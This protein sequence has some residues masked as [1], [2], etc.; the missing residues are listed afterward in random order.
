MRECHVSA[1]R[2]C[3]SAAGARGSAATDAPVRLQRLVGQRRVLEGIGGDSTVHLE[4]ASAESP[5]QVGE[6]Y[7]PPM[8]VVVLPGATSREEN[9]TQ[10][11]AH[12]VEHDQD[13]MVPA[14][15]F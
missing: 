8:D 10:H 12:L 1:E 7:P 11:I 15:A 5:A 6:I 4:L 3:R 2:Y 9:G 13:Q 14:A